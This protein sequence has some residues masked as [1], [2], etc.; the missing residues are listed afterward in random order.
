MIMINA[1]GGATRFAAVVA[2]AALDPNKNRDPSDQPQSFE[3][4]ASV[5]SYL[6]LPG[7]NAPTQVDS[8]EGSNTV[9]AAEKANAV[10]TPSP[11]YSWGFRREGG[12]VVDR[13]AP[14]VKPDDPRLVQA[15]EELIGAARS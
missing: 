15:V 10:R 11:D 8:S 7:F 1:I 13:F 14:D 12:E 2:E 9:T 3:L 5:A 4:N 6:S